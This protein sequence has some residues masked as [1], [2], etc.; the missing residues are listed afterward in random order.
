M[1]LLCL[2]DQATLD[3]W[4][5]LISGSL[6][7]GR[8]TLDSALLGACIRLG[9]ETNLSQYP[10]TQSLNLLTLLFLV[11]RSAKDAGSTGDLSKNLSYFLQVSSWKFCV[12]QIIDAVWRRDAAVWGSVYRWQM[13]VV[14]L[15][16]AP[17]SSVCCNL[18][19]CS[20]EQA[21]LP[22]RLLCY[23]QDW[24]S[25]KLI[26]EPVYTPN[27]SD[28]NAHLFKVLSSGPMNWQGLASKCTIGAQKLKAFSGRFTL[29]LTVVV[30]SLLKLTK[31][32]AMSWL[33]GSSCM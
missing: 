18:E 23:F 12:K 33:A 32:L 7:S 28:H 13:W 14:Y 6:I 15:E 26:T 20:V 3:A 10:H 27:L 24:R 31:Y 2:S 25:K 9:W 21:D 22:L 29:Y 1:L 11:S 5:L 30:A 4:S 8:P 17:V 16:G 19:K